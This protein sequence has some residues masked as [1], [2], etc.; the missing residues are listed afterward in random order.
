MIEV[1]PQ[2]TVIPEGIDPVACKYAEH[3]QYRKKESQ[4]TDQKT[5]GSQFSA[6]RF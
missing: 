3:G 6:K 4:E 2:K 1:C 5:I